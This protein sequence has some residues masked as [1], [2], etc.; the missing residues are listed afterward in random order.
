MYY[1]NW[2]LNSQVKFVPEGPGPPFACN[3]QCF[4]LPGKSEAAW[5]IMR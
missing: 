3:K 4:I 2:I 5:M 1:A